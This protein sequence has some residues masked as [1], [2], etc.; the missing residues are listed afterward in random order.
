MPYVEA[1]KKLPWTYDCGSRQ[2]AKWR[3][4]EPTSEF[5]DD[6]EI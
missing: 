6:E 2:E 5:S 3:N 1:E 4:I